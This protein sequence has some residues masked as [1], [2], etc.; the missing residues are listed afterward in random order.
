MLTVLTLIQ[1]RDRR[2][3]YKETLSV[4]EHAKRVNP[5][6]V[7]KTSIMLGHGEEDHEVK[8][9][10]QDMLDI[11]VEIFT[12]GQYLRPSKRH[13]PVKRM[14]PPEEYERWREIGMSMG[15]K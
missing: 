3:G 9:T 10:M 11:G 15:F 13:M 2:A 8:Q 1:V 7:T 6:L 4:L 5:N 12:L 14:V